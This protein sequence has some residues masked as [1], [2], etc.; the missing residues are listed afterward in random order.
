MWASVAEIAQVAMV[1]FLQVP[2]NVARGGD[3]A[4]HEVESRGL[5]NHLLSGHI[6]KCIRGGL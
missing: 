2:E 4:E 3:T 1:V 5:G 6:C